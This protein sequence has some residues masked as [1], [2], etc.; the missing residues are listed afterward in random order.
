[1]K[2]FNLLCISFLISAC[3]GGGGSSLSDSGGVSYNGSTSPAT[4]NEESAEDIGTAAGESVKRAAS[5]SSL[6]SAIS[7]VENNEIDLSEINELVLN[8]ATLALTP[9]GLNLEGV[10]SS[11]SISV[12]EPTQLSGAVTLNFV[13]SQCKLINSNITANGRATFHYNNYGDPSSGFSIT[14]TNFR[15]S[16]PG[17]DT[18]TLNMHIE[19]V[20]SSSCTYNSDF[21]GSDGNTHRVSSFSFTGNA[22]TGYNGSATFYHSRYGRTS[23]SVNSLTYGSCGSQPDGG[24]IAFSSTNGTSGTINFNSDCTVSGTWNNG[25]TSGSF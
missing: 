9:S 7:I 2:L 24:S 19:C 8:S 3:G 25:S 20:N 4:I 17:V 11:G 22:S 13:Y 1:M 12:N 14:Y 18:V 16:Q 23:I 10:C 15:V 6:P 5:S 21:V